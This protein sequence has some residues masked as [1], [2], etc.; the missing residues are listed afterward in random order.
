M[1]NLLRYKSF[2]IIL[3]LVICLFTKSESCFAQQATNNS[4]TVPAI[5]YNGDTMS[6]EYLPD[7]F[8]YSKYD[9]DTEEAAY[10]KRARQQKT[11]EAWTELRN[12]VYVTYPYAKRCGIIIN[13]INYHLAKIPTEEGQKAYLKTREKELRTEFTDPLSNMS[14]FQGKILM[15]LINRETGN[16]CY[17]IIKGYKGGMTARLYQTVAFFFDSNLKQPYDR[18]GDD[19]PIEKIVLEVQRMYGYRS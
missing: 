15:K 10:L 5:I 14:I 16:N 8:L 4:V 7:C 12:A 17:N 19:A 18:D 3:L 9:A 11:M 2:N 13:D 6:L 1:A